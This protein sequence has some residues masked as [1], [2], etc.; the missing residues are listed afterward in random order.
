MAAFAEYSAA[1]NPAT[2]DALVR[3]LNNLV[4]VQKK[5]EQRALAKQTASPPHGVHVIRE[6]R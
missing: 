2:L 5:A 6:T 4:T 3:A 1:S